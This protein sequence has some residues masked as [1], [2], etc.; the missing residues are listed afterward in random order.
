M[1]I[2][3]TTATTEYVVDI[4][5]AWVWVKLEDDLGLTLTEAQE[6]MSSGS[7]KAITYAIWIASKVDTP[8]TVWL[9]DL[10]GFDIED[11]AD[12]K[13]DGKVRIVD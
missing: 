5:Q 2:K 4:D 13:D 6:K 3:V 1:K 9:Q 7:T 11:D 10:T 12:P 8:Y